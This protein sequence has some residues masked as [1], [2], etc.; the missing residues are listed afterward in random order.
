MPARYYI[1][2]TPNQ[3]NF[4]GHGIAPFHAGTTIH[5]DE[6]SGQYDY[7]Q[8]LARMP[9]GEI[10]LWFPYQDCPLAEFCVTRLR[11]LRTG[12]TIKGYYESL[13]SYFVKRWFR[14]LYGAATAAQQQDIDALDDFAGIADI[15]RAFGRI[16]SPFAPSF[17][18]VYPRADMTLPELEKAG[19]VFI[20]Q[21]L[22]TYGTMQ[23]EVYAQ[24]IRQL[25]GQ[26]LIDTYIMHPRE[27]EAPCPGLT[28]LRLGAPIENFRGILAAKRLYAVFSTSSAYYSINHGNVT[29]I[30]A[31]PGLFTMSAWA[32]DVYG[33]LQ[34]NNP[35]LQ[36]TLAAS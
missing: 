10:E 18:Q 13:M 9:E 28:A 22:A 5:L 19:G 36:I 1:T 31:D 20:G 33:W 8:L 17:A 35:V 30:A 25:A 14:Q 16:P 3:A 6:S 4:I 7:P 29:I 2:T 23:P 32:H 12:I 15:D 24:I 34:Q 21:P 27:K 11:T 26:G